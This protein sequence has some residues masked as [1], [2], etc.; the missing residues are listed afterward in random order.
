MTPFGGVS[1]LQCSVREAE[2]VQSWPPLAIAGH[3]PLLYIYYIPP[4]G[5]LGVLFWRCSGGALQEAGY[6]RG[7]M[8][9]LFL[10]FLGVPDH[11]FGVSCMGI[12]SGSGEIAGVL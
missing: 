1:T 8:G 4:N 12:R 3:T 7:T 5:V 9:V 11:V 2:E 6:Y 10:G